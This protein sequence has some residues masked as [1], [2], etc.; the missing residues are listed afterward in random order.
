MIS[1]PA[2]VPTGRS[3]EPWWA[4]PSA[5]PVVPARRVRAG[6]ADQKKP[7]FFSE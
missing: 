1:P 3:G 4:G 2:M 6:R 7:S 5:V